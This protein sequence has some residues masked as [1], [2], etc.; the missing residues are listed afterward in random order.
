[1]HAVYEI[2]N[3]IARYFVGRVNNHLLGNDS[4]KIPVFSVPISGRVFTLLIELDSPKCNRIELCPRARVTAREGQ[5]LYL[6][7]A[8]DEDKRAYMLSCTQNLNS[9]GSSSGEESAFILTA[10]STDRDGTGAFLVSESVGNLTSEIDS[11]TL[12]LRSDLFLRIALQGI[13]EKRFGDE[14][15]LADIWQKGV[16]RL[17]KFGT[18]LREIS[19]LYSPSTSPNGACRV[20]SGFFFVEAQSSA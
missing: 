20:C 11:P 12:P 14:E 15:I 17:S 3:S 19:T 1:M 16:D 9:R 8:N 6:S 18:N 7:S 5:F 2:L 4:E 10:W 13:T